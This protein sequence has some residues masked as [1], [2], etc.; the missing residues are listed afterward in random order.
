[1]LLESEMVPALPRRGASLVPDDM[2]RTQNIEDRELSATTPELVHSY[3][4]LR[5]L[6]IIKIATLFSDGMLR[7][8]KRLDL[9]VNLTWR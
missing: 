6:G 9:V 8:M 5:G 4:E 7:T 3:V 1:M 2:V